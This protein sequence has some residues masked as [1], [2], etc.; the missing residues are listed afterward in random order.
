MHQKSL[1]RQTRQQHS[2]ASTHLFTTIFH[3]PWWLDAVCSDWDEVS[4]S[5]DGRVIARLPYM[6]KRA[7]GLTALCM[8]PLTHTLGPQLSCVIGEGGPTLPN[9]RSVLTQVLEK[10][11][12]HDY[13]SQTCDPIVDEALAAYALGYHTSVAYTQRI[14]LGTSV[15]QAFMGMRGKTRRLVRI[16]EKT[17]HL[18]RDLSIEEF[19]RLYAMS[20]REN[21]GVRWSATKARREEQLRIRVYEACRAHNATCLLGARDDNGVLHAAIMPVWGHGLMHYLQTARRHDAAQGA[22]HLLVWNAMKMAIERKMT[23]DFDGF[24]RPDAVN[25]TWGFGGTIHKR[26]VISKQRPLIHLARALTGRLSY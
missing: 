4:V 7:M 25:F 18:D 24:L 11:P 9:D 13:F 19:C 20:I 21:Y 23:F 3:E 15:E 10:L 8:P 16:G 26:L 14:P 22:V 1:D 5:M 12:P 2:S 6:R 17:L